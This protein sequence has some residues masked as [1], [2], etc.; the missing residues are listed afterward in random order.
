MK[1]LS[2]PGNAGGCMQI[3]RKRFYILAAILLVLGPGLPRHG[4]AAD[5]ISDGDAPKSKSFTL[6]PV[7]IDRLYAPNE[8]PISK[9]TV[10]LGDEGDGTY[11]WV[12]EIS[13]SMTD[14]Q[15][16]AVPARYLCHSKAQFVSPERDVPLTLSQGMLD[17]KLP[18]GYAVR[19]NNTPQD[20]FLL[21]QTMNNDVSAKKTL[22]YKFSI[23]YYPDSY[24]QMH[25]IKPLRQLQ[26]Y[27]NA[28]DVAAD[29]ADRRSKENLP[30]C[31]TGPM[32]YV[33]PGRHTYSSIIPSQ[34]LF[35]FTIHFI[36]LHLHTYGESLSLVDDTARQ[37]L[38]KGSGTTD[39]NESMLTN[40][41]HYSSSAGIRI[42]PSHVY[43]LVTVYNNPTHHMIDAMAIVRLYVED[44]MQ[45]ANMNRDVGSA[46]L[47]SD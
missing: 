23:Q 3:L 10:N 2:T 34:Q 38:W 7:Q 1:E 35:D 32:F 12:R 11:L 47:N 24:A 4:L 29:S 30:M 42:D 41:D 6:A 26:L 9:Q 39:A 31:T 14:P 43:K 17:L 27:V 46:K 18:E 45:V 15:G 8:G 37:T 33:P 21:A 28:K 16:K 40:T 19:V 25:G 22:I 36:K 20:V 5:G 13:L 44:N